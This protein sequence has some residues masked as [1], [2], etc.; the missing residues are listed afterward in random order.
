MH[1]YEIDL[2]LEQNANLSLNISPGSVF[3]NI[4]MLKTYSR[5]YLPED[6]RQKSQYLLLLDPGWTYLKQKQKRKSKYRYE[7]VTRM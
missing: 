5:L 3:M 1:F 4:P 2:V 6:N 7:P